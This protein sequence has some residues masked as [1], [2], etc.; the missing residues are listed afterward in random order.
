MPSGPSDARV[1]VVEGGGDVANDEACVSTSL[2]EYLPGQVVSKCQ[3]TAGEYLRELGP[4]LDCIVSFTDDKSFLN[5]LVEYYPT[6]PLV[7]Y[8][9]EITDAGVDA[10]VS[11]D[12]S[13]EALANAVEREVREARKENHLEEENTKLTALG[14]YA[15]EITACETV[16]EVTEQTIKATRGALNFDFCVFALVEGDQIVPYGSTLPMKAERP[17]A[18][19]EG[20]A[21]RTLARG[22]TQRVGNLQNDPDAEF[23]QRG[24]RSVVSV[25]V[26]TRGVLQVVSVEEDVYTE[27]DVE[28]LEIL[29]GY[30]NEA[31]QRLDREATLRAERDRFHAFF[32]ALPA[33]ALYLEA[34]SDG[35]VQIREA[36]AA[37]KRLFDETV[38][39]V[40]GPAGAVVQTKQE[41]ELFSK[42][43]N[44]DGPVTERVTRELDG[45][46]ETDLE[47]TLVPVGESGPTSSAYAIYV[48]DASLP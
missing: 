38:G 15:Q 21:G 44:A 37:Y 32:E 10:V 46:G 22:E 31:L 28:F 42:H 6:I 35:T 25:P 12:Q 4:T 14:Q 26:G 29:A 36:N 33:P 27:R 2:Q 19:G 1:L 5:T 11:P 41:H 16:E 3:L 9:D 47:V 43:L 45:R 24:F 13:I 7:L 34:E 18:I 39:P 40:R 30:T 20:I 8:T 48:A 23:K 17:I